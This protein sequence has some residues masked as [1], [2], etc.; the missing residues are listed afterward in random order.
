MH[1][2]EVITCYSSEEERQGKKNKGKSKE[3]NILSPHFADTCK[4]S[5]IAVSKD[6][7]RK[8]SGVRVFRE[9]S[10]RANKDKVQHA[11]M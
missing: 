5:T 10:G 11:R 6:L 9:K 2:W 7:F 4:N 3:F 8:D 1:H